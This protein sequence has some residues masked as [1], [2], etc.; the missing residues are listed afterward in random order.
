M[1]R[2]SRGVDESKSRLEVDPEDLFRAGRLVSSLQKG[3]RSEI[4]IPQ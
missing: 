3:V 4:L 2:D 1:N